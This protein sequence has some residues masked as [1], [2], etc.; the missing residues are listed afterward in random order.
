MKQIFQVGIPAGIQST[1]INFSNVLLQ[2]SVNS[3][4]STAMAGIYGCQQY[5]SDFLYV[6][7]NSVTQACMSF[8]SQNY[9]VRK[10]ETYG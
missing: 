6:S 10:Y 8:T 7:V 5:V 9:G 1:V 2:S 3:F 4:G